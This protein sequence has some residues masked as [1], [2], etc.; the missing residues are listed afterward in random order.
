MQGRQSGLSLFP[1][2]T[3][4]LFHTH[5]QLSLWSPPVMFSRPACS[6]VFPGSYQPYTHWPQQNESLSYPIILPKLP[7]QIILRLPWD[8][9]LSLN[10]LLCS[11]DWDCTQLS[12]GLILTIEARG[13]WG[14]VNRV[15]HHQRRGGCMLNKQGQKVSLH[16]DS[17]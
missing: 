10:L 4:S 9:C 15:V 11:E 8:I 5:T 13:T 14:P 16:V 2:L 1:Y 3:V 7:W 17:G 6:S 12:L